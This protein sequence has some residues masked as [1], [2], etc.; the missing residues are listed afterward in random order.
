MSQALFHAGQH[1]PVI[2]GLD[3]D[4]SIRPKSRLREPGREE[5]G[6]G[7]APEN[8]TLGARGD[9]GGEER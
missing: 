2:A 1:R 3:V 5:V 7:D 9:T 8:L 4:H 6:P